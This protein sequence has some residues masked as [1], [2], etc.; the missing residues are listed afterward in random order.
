[1]RKQIYGNSSSTYSRDRKIQRT[2]GRFFELDLVKWYPEGSQS[3]LA[4]V[5]GPVPECDNFVVHHSLVFKL[6]CILL[7][8]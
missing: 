3:I 7:I 6:L 8:K 5:L 2:P 1:V 4:G